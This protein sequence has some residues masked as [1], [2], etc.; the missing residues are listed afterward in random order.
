[1]IS[2]LAGA[3]DRP[4]ALPE[5]ELRHSALLLRTFPAKTPASQNVLAARELEKHTHRTGNAA[6]PM[7]LPQYLSGKD[8]APALHISHGIITIHRG[9]EMLGVEIPMRELSAALATMRIPG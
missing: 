2:S 5:P 7:H 9:E 4:A 8:A 1:V 3:C 6:Q